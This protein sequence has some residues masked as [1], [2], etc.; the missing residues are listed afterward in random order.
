MAHRT[1]ARRLAAIVVGIV[2]VGAGITVF[3]VTDGVTGLRP[4]HVVSAVL[5]VAG[6]GFVRYGTNPKFRQV[7]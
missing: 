1:R 5:V 7:V 2:L 3:V 4:S 6:L